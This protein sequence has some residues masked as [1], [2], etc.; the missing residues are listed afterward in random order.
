MS[1]NYIKCRSI[2]IN[3]NQMLAATNLIAHTPRNL[4]DRI[5]FGIHKIAAAAAAAF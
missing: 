2:D 3:R 1:E 4:F 5:E